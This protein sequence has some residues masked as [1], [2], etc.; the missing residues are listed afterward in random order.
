MGSKQKKQ[1][2]PIS[3]EVI[4][5]IMLGVT[6]GV[7]AI[8]LVK[9]LK[10][11][12]MAASGVIAGCL[13]VFAVSM[14]IIQKRKASEFT[15]QLAVSLGV[16]I[17]VFII[18]LFSGDYYSDDFSMFLAVIALSGMY[19]Q[20]TITRVQ[21]VLAVILL[22][23][24]YMIHPEK[25]DPFGQYAMCVAITALGGILFSLTIGRGRAYI[26]IGKERAEEA[27]L[28][29]ESIVH[30]GEELKQNF[31][32]SFHH[33]ENMEAV[34]ARL[35]K[36]AEELKNG[37]DNITSGTREVSDSCNEVEDT[38]RLTE[39]QVDA[40]SQEVRVFES[41]LT[42]NQKNINTMNSQMELV[43]KTMHEA[44]EVFRHLQAQMRQ[45]ASMT[46]QLN[47]ISSNTTILALNASIEAAR[48]GE[49]GKGFAVVASNVK[50]LAVNSNDCSK[51]VSD[52]VSQMHE[53]VENTSKQLQTSTDALDSSMKTLKKLDDDFVKLS[54]NF[55]MLYGNIEA[56]NGNVR[57]VD[58][59]FVQL[60]E[61]ILDMSNSSAENQNAVEAITNAIDQYKESMSEIIDDTKQVQKLSVAM[62]EMSLEEQ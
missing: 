36:N 32:T 34:N 39:T 27:E 2:K 57:Q 49:A 3:P 18:S 25:A 50:E 31:E 52:I 46:E 45:I 24:M 11:G 61:R 29:L 53:K 55:N 19:L 8:F 40:L 60:R 28:L 22:S 10:A 1:K 13:V 48:A 35:Y 16:M 20:P 47:D 41:A 4:F 12:E 17:L 58:A 56:Q 14:F 6:F 30:S 62:L 15:K 44:D 51:Q 59:I 26:E 5:K 38:I 7:A 23:V 33:I 54:E 9:N 43:K 37:S 42:E 21:A